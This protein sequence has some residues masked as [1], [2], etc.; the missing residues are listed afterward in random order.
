MSPHHGRICTLSSA[1]V[2]ACAV[3]QSTAVA[4]PADLRSPGSGDA[5][6]VAAVTDLRSPDTRDLGRSAQPATPAVDL[7]S[8]DSRDAHR[9]A[10]AAV[11]PAVI[12][13]R[14]P[15]VVDLGSVRVVAREPV[16]S[17]SSPESGFDWGDAGIGAGGAIAVVLLGLGA[18]LMVTHRRRAIKPPSAVAH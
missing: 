15:D 8:P 5:P 14:S 9:T 2:L 13:R 1:I 10:A 7:R 11:T 6:R 4:G 12:D 3:S 18:A 17:I 16:V